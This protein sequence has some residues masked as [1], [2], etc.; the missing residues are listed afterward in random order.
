MD[1]QRSGLQQGIPNRF[2]ILRWDPQFVIR[3]ARIVAA[4]HRDANAIPAQLNKLQRAKIIAI[5]TEDCERL[6]RLRTRDSETCNLLAQLLDFNFIHDDVAAKDLQHSLH[7]RALNYSGQA[8][9]AIE[10]V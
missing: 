7:L 8:F 4:N 10:Y 6:A 9:A 3:D 5:E 2:S 1:F